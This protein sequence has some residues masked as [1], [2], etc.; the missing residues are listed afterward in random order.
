[1]LR[2]VTG[3]RCSLLYEDVA[4]AFGELAR[5]TDDFVAFEGDHAH[6]ASLAI[7]PWLRAQALVGELLFHV[8]QKRL[9]LLGSMSGALRVDEVVGLRHSSG[10]IPSVWR[11]IFVIL[12]RL[13]LF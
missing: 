9:I 7:A 2:E 12:A 11:L 8:P 1:M 5:L 13:R 4:W 10:T 6:H 3:R